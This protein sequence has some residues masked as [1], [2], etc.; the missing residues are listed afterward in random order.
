[1]A[2][3]KQWSIGILTG[4]LSAVLATASERDWKLERDKN[5]I[6]VYTREIANSPYIA[7]KATTVIRAPVETLQQQLGRGDLPAGTVNTRMADSAYN[8]LWR[9]RKI[10]ED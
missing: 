7:V 3:R 2:S 4:P 9:L 10:A 5:N 1:M 6:R 8:D